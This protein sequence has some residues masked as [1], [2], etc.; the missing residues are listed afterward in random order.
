MNILAI[1]TAGKTAAVAVM[2]DDTLLYEMASNTGLTHSET[3]LPM[4]D[5]ALKA[6]GLNVHFAGEVPTQ[7]ELSA[8]LDETRGQPIQIPVHTG[9]LRSMQKA[10]YAP[11]PL[12]H[13][14]LVLAD[15]AHFTSPIRRYP[16]L[17]IHRIL[18]EMLNGVSASQLQRDFNE[19]AQQ[20]SEKSSKQEVAAVRIERDVEDLYKAEYMHNHLGEVY[21]GTVAGITPRGVFVELAGPADRQELDAGF[22]HEDPGRRRRRCAGSY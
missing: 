9:I 18:T 8:I 1:D 16:D 3:L 6:C 12:G 22:F 14:G 2:R 17:A 4:V 21:T 19:F 15:Y 11:Q 20:A 10:R 5:T 7:L 13:Y